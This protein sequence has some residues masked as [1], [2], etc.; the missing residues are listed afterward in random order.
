M[1]SGL[2]NGGTTKHAKHIRVHFCLVVP[3]SV[4]RVNGIHRARQRRLP[5]RVSSGQG[6]RIRTMS[7][8]DTA[9][10]TTVAADT[11]CPL[12]ATPPLPFR[13]VRMMP[14]LHHEGLFRSRR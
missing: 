1:R 5:T 7:A 12:R 4:L 9:D 10:T 3:R 2:G 11:L 13:A 8:T 6:G 14:R